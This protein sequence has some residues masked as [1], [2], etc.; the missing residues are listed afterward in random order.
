MKDSS[1]EEEGDWEITADGLYMA[2]RGFLTRRGYC[3]ANQCRNCPYINWRNNPSWQPVAHEYVHAM[4]VSFKAVTGAQTL[5]AYHTEHVHQGT[6]EEREQHK[7]M[8][9]HYS[10]LLKQWKA[11]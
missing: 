7:A 4:R 8:I 6:S 2:T 5:L 10:F 9:E 3:C 11:L 1:V